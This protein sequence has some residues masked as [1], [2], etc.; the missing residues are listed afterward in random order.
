M[1]PVRLWVH[2]AMA[3]SCPPPMPLCFTVHTWLLAVAGGDSW[4]VEALKPVLSSNT[5]RLV[6]TTRTSCFSRKE[7]YGDSGGLWGNKM[8]LLAVCV[9]SGDWSCN[10]WF[11]RGSESFAPWYFYASVLLK[12]CRGNTASFCHQD[13]H[14]CQVLQFGLS[15]TT[16]AFTKMLDVAGPLL[17]KQMSPFP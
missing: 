6:F 11:R 10:Q 8:L 2:G 13:C 15:G 9:G 17:T 7:K 16:W 5:D 12:G 1:Y 4:A 3:R 14:H